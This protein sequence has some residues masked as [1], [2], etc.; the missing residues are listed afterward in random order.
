[1]L[2][3]VVPGLPDVY[4]VYP[5]NPLRL[6]GFRGFSLPRFGGRSTT[7]LP[8]KLFWG[9][10][11]GFTLFLSVSQRFSPCKGRYAPFMGGFFLISGNFHLEF[12]NYLPLV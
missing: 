8:G 12:G 7:G 4:Q 3:S 5:R 10:P 9:E 6:N 2:I 11:A 1:M